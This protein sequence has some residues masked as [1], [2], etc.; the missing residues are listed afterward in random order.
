MTATE[1]DVIEAGE[2]RAARRQLVALAALAGVGAAVRFVGWPE[3][4]P[5][6]SR[7][8]NVGPRSF[9]F[10]HSD[11]AAVL[12][13]GFKIV[14]WGVSIAAVLGIVLALAR[15]KRL[16]GVSLKEWVFLALVL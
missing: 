9:V 12:R 16:F 10:N 14:T 8:S 1:I 5:V 15:G 11:L 2:S 3:F 13:I 7:Y 4:D 6:V